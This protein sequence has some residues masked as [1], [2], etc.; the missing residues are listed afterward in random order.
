M[1]AERCRLI[2]RKHT[3]NLVLLTAILPEISHC[4]TFS[5][6][7]GL[8]VKPNELKLVSCCVSQELQKEK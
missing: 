3:E 5:D 4:S 1:K 8:N 6:S 2:R 7:D